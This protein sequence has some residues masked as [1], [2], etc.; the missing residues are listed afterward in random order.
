M[1]KAYPEKDDFFF[2]KSGSLS[3]RAFLYGIPHHQPPLPHPGLH[4]NL[5]TEREHDLSV[6]MFI[7]MSILPSLNSARNGHQVHNVKQTIATG[8]F[9]CRISLI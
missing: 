4:V 3:I 8:V 2:K 6:M 5:Q 1:K 7:L 9:A